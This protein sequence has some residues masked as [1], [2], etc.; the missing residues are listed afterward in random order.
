MNRKGE[1]AGQTI[2]ALPLILLFLVAGGGIAGALYANFGT[3][4]D[5][6]LQESYVLH[7]VVANCIESG[8]LFYNFNEVNLFERC[9][10]NENVLDEHLV[11]IQ[12]ID[13]S[14]ELVKE[15]VAEGVRDFETRCLLTGSNVPKCRDEVVSFNDKN[16]RLLVASDH[17]SR[18]IL[19]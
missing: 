1:I 6:R 17:K 9:K 2:K 16:Y 11:L 13:S 5:V 10:L 18:R 12:E 8:N 4:Y 7:G 14:G 15:E 19:G 3:G